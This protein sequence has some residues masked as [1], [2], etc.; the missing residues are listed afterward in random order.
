M[1]AALANDICSTSVFPAAR[2][3]FPGM[4]NAPDKNV[5][6]EPPEQKAVVA[7]YTNAEPELR[8]DS[9]GVPGSHGVGVKVLLH[10]SSKGLAVDAC[11]GLGMLA[12]SAS[13]DR[14]GNSDT[15]PSELK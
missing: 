14:L 7:I 4:A 15:E 11:E 3:F 2:G 12:R 9:T 8:F 1:P 10:Q 6:T 5:T 13:C